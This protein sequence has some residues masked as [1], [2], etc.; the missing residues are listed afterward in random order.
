MRRF[1]KKVTLLGIALALFLLSSVVFAAWVVTGNGNAYSAATNA[2]PLTT[3]AA[4]TAAQLYPGGT[5]DVAVKINN[6]NPFDVKVT[7][8]E[9][10]GTITSDA[11]SACD[12]STGVTYTTQNLSS[13]NVV[14][15]GGSLSLSLNNA[16]AMSNSSDSSCQGSTFT[17]PVKF[18]AGS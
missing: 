17:I 18:T 11:G 1:S 5:G 2:Q 12:P 7:K 15:A 14:P 3:S 4:T 9:G 8:I 10:N 13:G 16:A 6:P